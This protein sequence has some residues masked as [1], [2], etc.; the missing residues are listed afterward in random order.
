[1][2]ANY[3]CG[4]RHCSEAAEALQLESADGSIHMKVCIHP[5]PS[6]ESSTVTKKK[7]MKTNREHLG[8]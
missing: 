4:G 2:L 3:A 6:Q 1:M 5:T 7:K 8:V